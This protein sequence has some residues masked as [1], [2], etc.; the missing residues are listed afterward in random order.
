MYKQCR[1]EQS[2]ARQR[3]LERGLLRTMT[4]KRFEEI[5]ICDLCEE[6]GIPRKS[7]YRYFSGKEGA[8]YALIDHAIMDF[9]T[10]SSID[11][12]RE[13]N[14]DAV[15]Y[16]AHIFHYW[17]NNKLLLDVLEKNNL[18]GLLIQRA[19]EY[20]KELDTMPPFFQSANRQLRDYATMFAVCGMMTLLVQWHRDGFSQSV[21][22]MAEL[23]IHLFSE[24][25]F[26][27]P[28]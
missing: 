12:A 27:P 22:Q 26:S 18:S 1:T 5:S 11:S 6:M 16:M 24:P 3:E 23:A 21:D 10:Y 7:F 19:I 20:T 25:L 28:K 8:L 17:V 2:A 14:K 13:Q 9:D 4:K 15:K